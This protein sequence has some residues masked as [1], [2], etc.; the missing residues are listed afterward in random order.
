MA[1]VARDDLWSIP[2]CDHIRV[3]LP[4]LASGVILVR[5]STTCYQDHMHIPNLS[6]RTSSYMA[7]SISLR[8]IYAMFYSHPLLDACS[9]GAPAPYP[10][11]FEPPSITDPISIFAQ[12]TIL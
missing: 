1:F 9:R 4:Q 6:Q 2:S 12:A 11:V 3:E 5:V 10:Q 7:Q 8:L